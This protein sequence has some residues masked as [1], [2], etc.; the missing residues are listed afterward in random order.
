MASGDV[1]GAAIQAHAQSKSEGKIIV[2]NNVGDGYEIPLHYLFREFQEM[3]ELEKRALAECKGNVLEVGAG[4][5]SHARCLRKTGMD[6]FL[7]DTSQGAVQYLSSTGF[8]AEKVDYF[9]FRSTEKFDTILMMMNGIGIV[10]K[11]NRF[12]EFFDKA[13][14]LLSSDGQIICDSADLS[15]LYEDENGEIWIDLNS[16]YYGEVEFKMKFEEV[17]TDWFPW[18]FV[19]FDTLNFYASENGFDCECLMTDENSQFL[20]RLTAKK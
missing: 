4:A 9:D 7:I 15:Y 8:R 13:K 12:Q 10:Q 17:E 14:S 5:G 2:E 16:D 20:A 18:L 11:V 6:P 1:F 19:D 3:P